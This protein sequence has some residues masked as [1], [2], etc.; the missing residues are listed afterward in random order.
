MLGMFQ[1]NENQKYDIHE[2][3]KVPRPLFPCPQDIFNFK[4]YRLPSF[5]SFLLHVISV[6]YD[7]LV[8]D[9]AAFAKLNERTKQ[10]P[11]VKL[12]FVNVVCIV[13]KAK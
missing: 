12:L 10:K 13:Q 3:G 6:L 1:H 4:V 11:T 2:M 8:I 9:E 7:V 5:P